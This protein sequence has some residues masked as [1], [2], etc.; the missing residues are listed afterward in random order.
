VGSPG[1]TSSI[2]SILI[3]LAQDEND[4]GNLKMEVQRLRNKCNRY[5]KMI[6][7]LESKWEM[8]QMH[9]EMLQKDVI[10]ILGFQNRL[11]TMYKGKSYE[12]M[13]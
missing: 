10:G 3:L 2:F 1:F 13:E 6:K 5:E 7:D 12:L 9:L 8:H 11:D 4:N